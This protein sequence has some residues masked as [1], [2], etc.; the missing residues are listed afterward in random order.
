MILTEVREGGK[1]GRRKGRRWGWN[2]RSVKTL[3]P[4]SFRL[5][6]ASV[7]GEGWDLLFFFIREWWDER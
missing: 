7:S 5:L 3:A 2:D 1:E 6:E 4:M